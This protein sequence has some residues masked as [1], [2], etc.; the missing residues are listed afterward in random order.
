[1]EHDSREP[2]HGDGLHED[3]VKL[4]SR[5]DALRIFGAGGATAILATLG[6]SRA[7][8]ATPTGEVPTETAGPYPATGPTAR[9]SS[10]TP[11]SCAT[12]SVGAS[13]AAGRSPRASRSGS[14]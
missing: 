6:A 9:T 13:G 10:T 4:A 1:M 8:S 11:A 5:R 12:T 7:M 14:T 2:D 3:L